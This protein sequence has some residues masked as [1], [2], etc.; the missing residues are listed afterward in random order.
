MQA[1]P[2]H[3]VAGLGDAD[4]VTVGPAEYD[5]ARQL[6][7][8]TAGPVVARV[9]S[10]L[11]PLLADAARSLDRTLWLVPHD[12]TDETCLSVTTAVGARTLLVGAGGLDA[13]ASGRTA[14][15]AGTSLRVTTHD[16]APSPDAPTPP[17]AGTG[18]GMITSGSTAEPRHVL[19]AWDRLE[20]EART[21]A[22]ALSFPGPGASVVCAA[23]LSHAY[24]FVVG[25]LGALVSESRLVVLPRT[26]T[27][28]RVAALATRYRAEVFVAV[29]AQY[30]RMRRAASEPLDGG[31]LRVCVSA[32]APLPPAVQESFTASFGRRITNHYGTTTSGSIARTEG[33]EPPDCVGIPYP[34]VRMRTDP[35]SGEIVAD[36]PWSAA[37][38][39]GEATGDLGH[40]EGERW[41]VDG[42]LADQVNIH[43]RKTTRTR[44][45]S[46]IASCPG[47]ADTAVDVVRTSTGDGWVVA[48]VAAEDAAEAAGLAAS[49]SAA[50]RNALPSFA[51]PKRVVLV[52]SI[53]RTERGKLRRD[54]LPHVS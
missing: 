52:P 54:R 53:P 3:V 11:V 50:C 45:E 1:P 12:E 49:V 43:G 2:S 6:L 42:R 9:E 28:N 15:L 5:M 18:L 14:R 41:F 23:P 24:G 16:C 31:L 32:G 4:D 40:A 20:Q 38:D 48:F 39:G 51:R 22:A 35:G 13:P 27:G 10:A 47:V 34:G 26:V 21:V 30:A 36:A 25:C 33:P 46:V 8:S 37:G 44:I 17:V 19:R 7:A 29:P